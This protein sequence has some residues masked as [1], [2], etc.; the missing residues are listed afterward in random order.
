MLT[1]IWK[2]NISTIYF[3]YL[4]TLN[5]LKQGKIAHVCTNNEYIIISV[6][7]KIEQY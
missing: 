4:S 3:N 1:Y 2:S 5:C 7:E 6:D